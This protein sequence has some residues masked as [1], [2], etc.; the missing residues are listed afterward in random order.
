MDKMQKELQPTD[1]VKMVAEMIEEEE[2]AS[3]AAEVDK[4]ADMIAKMTDEDAKALKE[5]LF[6][7]SSGTSNNDGEEEEEEEEEQRE[8]EDE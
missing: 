2:A 1:A 7:T 6:P 4:M 8:G 3:N 5:K